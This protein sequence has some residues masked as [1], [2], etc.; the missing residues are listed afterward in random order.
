MAI[1]A[2]FP[3]SS[4]LGA[5]AV[6]STSAPNNNSSETATELPNFTRISSFEIFL[7]EGCKR[8][9][10]WKMTFNNGKTNDEG[11]QYFCG[12]ADIKRYIFCNDFHLRFYMILRIFIPGLFYNQIPFPSGYFLQLILP[13]A[14]F[15]GYDHPHEVHWQQWSGPG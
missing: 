14:H 11:R 10:K 15:P 8:V 1:A 7:F 2:S 12:P 9:A 4:Q 3:I 13:G 5:M 6:A